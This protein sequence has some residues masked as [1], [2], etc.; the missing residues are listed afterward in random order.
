MKEA[1]ERSSSAWRYTLLAVSV[2]S[3][4]LA[5]KLGPALALIHSVTERFIPRTDAGRSPKRPAFPSIF[6]LERWD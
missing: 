1:P 5:V 6:D 3:V 2:G 4:V